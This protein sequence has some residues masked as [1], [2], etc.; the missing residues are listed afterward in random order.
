MTYT[1]KKLKYN[2]REREVQKEVIQDGW[3][4][5][6]KGWPDFLCYRKGLNGKIEAFFMEVKRKPYNPHTKYNDFK[7]KTNFIQKKTFDVK[8][9]PQQKEMHSVLKQLGFEVKVIYKD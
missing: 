7:T 8:L 1:P 6:Y 5:L 2:Q 9:S 4:V 3:K